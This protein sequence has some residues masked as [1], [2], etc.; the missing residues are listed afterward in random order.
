MYEI[1]NNGP[2]QEFVLNSF[3]YSSRV[4]TIL[5]SVASTLKPFVQ[6]DIILEE[7]ESVLLGRQATEWA[8]VINSRNIIESNI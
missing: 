5:K 7:N 1:V 3:N 2:Q 4:N 6:T 8:G